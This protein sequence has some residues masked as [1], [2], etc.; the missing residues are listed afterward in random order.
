MIASMKDHVVIAEALL[1][2]GASPN[3]Q[4]KVCTTL[5]CCVCMNIH[6]CMYDIMTRDSYNYVQVRVGMMM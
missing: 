6:T 3:L 1:K 4:N 2:A 5:C